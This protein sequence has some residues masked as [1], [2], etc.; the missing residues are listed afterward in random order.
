MKKTKTLCLPGGLELPVKLEMETV[1]CYETTEQALEAQV[2]K[3]LLS[4]AAET[5][6]VQQM[7]AGQILQSNFS[8]SRN[9]RRYELRSILECHEMI[10]AVV[11]GQWKNEDMS[12]G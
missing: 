4:A 5:R 3:Q 7:Q 10:A 2:A 12:H 6:A 8:V 9:D 1:R 11:P